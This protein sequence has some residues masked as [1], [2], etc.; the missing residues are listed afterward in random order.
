MKWDDSMIGQK[1]EAAYPCG[2]Q[3]QLLLKRFGR[4]KIKKKR[5]IGAAFLVMP[6]LFKW[7]KD[8]MKELFGDFWDLNP[9]PS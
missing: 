5:K 9:H 2:C 1:E 3:R 8:M 4:T 7:N 6:L